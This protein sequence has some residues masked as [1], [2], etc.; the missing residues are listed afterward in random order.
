MRESP[1]SWPAWC[2]LCCGGARPA[3]GSLGVQLPL[4]IECSHGGVQALALDVQPK[5]PL[6]RSLAGGT[7]ARSVF[8]AASLLENRDLASEVIF[9]A[10]PQA[11]ARS[12][13]GLAL[14]W[15]MWASD[16]H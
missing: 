16:W 11:S 12:R 8:R 5:T 9:Q 10:P 2:A 6:W 4:C 3:S 7:N 15:R 14:V 13:T 1:A